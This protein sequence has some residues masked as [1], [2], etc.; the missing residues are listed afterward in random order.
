MISKSAYIGEQ[1]KL[2]EGVII[3]DDVFIGDYVSIGHHVVIKKGTIIGDYATIGNFNSLGQQPSG[4]KNMITSTEQHYEPLLIGTGVKTGDHCV[5]Y[6]ATILHDHT[7]IGD[8][9]SIREQVIVGKESVI[10]RQSIIENH[11]I[12]GE[13]VTIQ[14]GCYVTAHML[15]EDRVFLGP[16]CSTSNDKYMRSGGN[17]L[18]GPVI[19]KGAKLGNHAT[20][21]PG[22]VIGEN[23]LVGAGTTV[24]KDVPP[25]QTVIGPP[26]RIKS[27]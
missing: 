25:S 7:F 15:I 4:N 2:G 1:V 8:L 12:I 20:L 13:K 22:V 14:T 17:A 3:E 16:C 5:I 9:A 27:I 21:L 11:T 23:A 26:G 19:K 6:C 18:K 10:G 24:V